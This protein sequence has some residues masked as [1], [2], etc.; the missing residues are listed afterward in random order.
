MVSG[1]VAR[2]LALLLHLL[3]VSVCLSVSLEDSS[4]GVAGNLPIQLLSVNVIASS[5]TGQENPGSYQQLV[6]CIYRVGKSGNFIYF[7]KDVDDFL[8]VLTSSQR[9]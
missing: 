3:C 7:N 8:S 5:A 1:L 9:S 2:W 6:R 4:I